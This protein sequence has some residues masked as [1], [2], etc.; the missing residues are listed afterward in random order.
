MDQ[1]L[2]AKESRCSTV[3]EFD[4]G[5]QAY[6]T[7][8]PCQHRCTHWVRVCIWKWCS[9][10]IKPTMLA[11]AW[12]S[13]NSTWAC[14]HAVAHI[15]DTTLLCSPGQM[16]PSTTKKDFSRYT[17][18]G[19]PLHSHSGPSFVC[20]VARWMGNNPHQSMWVT[21]EPWPIELYPQTQD[22]DIHASDHNS[23]HWSH[24]EVLASV[25]DDV[26]IHEFPTSSSR[27]RGCQEA[28]IATGISCHWHADVS[29]NISMEVELS[30][31][32]CSQDQMLR[33]TYSTRLNS[34]WFAAASTPTFHNVHGGLELRK[35]LV[36]STISDGHQSDRM[37]VIA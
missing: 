3:E 9:C 24:R 33:G 21:T 32:V 13:E 12:A 14:T 20:R 30:P 28:S 4:T 11:L 31:R 29:A 26:E 16:P 35:A 27:D 19:W 25:N 34:P 17:Q 6:R 23:P 15:R 1:L 5:L 10:H 18:D 36:K 2:D 22:I 7:F 37:D 8:W